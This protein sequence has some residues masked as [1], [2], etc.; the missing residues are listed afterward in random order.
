MPRLFRLLCLL[1]ALTAAPPAG[2]ADKPSADE[3]KTLTLRAAGLISERG[4]AAVRDLFDSDGPFKFGETYVNVIDVNGTWLIYPPNPKN[5]GKSVLNVM[6]A[7][8][9]LLVQEILA[10]AKG[11]G[12]GWVEYRWLNP[13][14]N[15]IEP[16][17]SFVKAV[18]DRQAVAYIGIYK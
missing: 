16:K 12:E 7:D 13:A 4:V 6:D 14:S 1:F 11:P 9:K 18:P 10:V 5:E 3:I 2:A 15:R 8:G 17:A